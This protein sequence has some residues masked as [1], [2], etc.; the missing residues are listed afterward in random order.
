MAGPPRHQ[1]QQALGL[2]GPAQCPAACHSEGDPN[3]PL[4]P[5]VASYIRDL[6]NPQEFQDPET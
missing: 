3:G 5:Q 4:S 1:E 6:I 2:V